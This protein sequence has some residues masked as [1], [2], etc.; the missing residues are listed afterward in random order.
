MQ[1]Y[2]GYTNVPGHDEYYGRS[3]FFGVRAKL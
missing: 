1:S 2:Q 3:F